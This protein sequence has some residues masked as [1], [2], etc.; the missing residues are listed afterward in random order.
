[1]QDSCLRAHMSLELFIMR[2]SA[3]E[4]MN[5]NK[6]YMQIRFGNELNIRCTWTKI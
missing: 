3:I 1:M 2:S 5:F 6:N 4:K